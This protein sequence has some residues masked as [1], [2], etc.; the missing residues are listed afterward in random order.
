M[1]A[2][3]LDGALDMV[4]R[5]KAGLWSRRPED[6]LGPGLADDDGGGFVLSGLTPMCV[7]GVRRFGRY[8]LLVFPSWA[9]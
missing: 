2:K 6:T 1:T 8:L 9:R 3:V 4:Y 7:L 5:I